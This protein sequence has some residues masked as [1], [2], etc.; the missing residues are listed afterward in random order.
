MEKTYFVTLT[1]D[2]EVIKTEYSGLRSLQSA[3][4]GYIEFF[5]QKMFNINGF[6]YTV[7]F[8]CDEEYMIKNSG[9][10]IRSNAI[11]SLLSG[12][13]VYGSVALMPVDGDDD[14]KGYSEEQCGIFIE[15]LKRFVESSKMK[16][17]EYHR[18]NDGIVEI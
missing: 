6:Y 16:L 18:L 8:Y 9:K 10:H 12:V 3:V 5:S 11:A 4:G 14:T 7:V 17:L 1:A 2:D 15:E 13:R